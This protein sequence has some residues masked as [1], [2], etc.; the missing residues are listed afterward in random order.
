MRSHHLI[1]HLVALVAAFASPLLAIDLAKDGRALARIAVPANPARLEKMALTDLQEFLNRM[2][3]ATFE[4]VEESQIRP[5]EPAIHLGWT[6]AAKASGIDYGSL[7]KEEWVVKADANTLIITGGRPAGTFYGVWQFLNRLGCYAMAMDCYSTPAHQTLTVT[8]LSLQG[9]PSFAGRLLYND[10]PGAAIVGGVPADLLE[11]YR[12][13][14]LR[15]GC[16][17][18][19]THRQKQYHYGDLFN[20][21][22][23]PFHHTL[24]VYVPPEKYFKEHP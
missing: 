1:L 24:T 17:G 18:E 7:G 10:F 4:A 13:F 12:L 21:S 9:K 8:A 3:G 11:Q 16:N 14:A 2:T 19:Q 6:K 23:T 15:S 22:T 20:I 5:D